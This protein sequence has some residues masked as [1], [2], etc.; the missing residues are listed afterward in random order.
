MKEYYLRSKFKPNE[1]W[2]LYTGDLKL[3][4]D[5][6]KNKSRVTQWYSLVFE[7]GFRDSITPI[8]SDVVRRL[9]NSIND[10]AYSKVEFKVNESVD[11]DIMDFVKT[12]EKSLQLFSEVGV[13]WSLV[14]GKYI[15][16]IYVND[17][18]D[19]KQTEF[20]IESHYYY[21]YYTEKINNQTEQY[22]LTTTIDGYFESNELFHLRNQKWIPVPIDTLD[23]LAEIPEEFNHGK[24]T[25]FIISYDSGFNN[26]ISLVELMD[27]ALSYM[28]HGTLLSMPRT[29]MPEDVAMKS[30][31]DKSVDKQSGLVSTLKTLV[32]NVIKV[33]YLD[34]NYQKIDTEQPV[35]QVDNY[36]KVKDTAL[37]EILN[38][39]G[40][41]PVSLGVESLSANTSGES[42]NAREKQTERFRD[43]LLSLRIPQL[44][45]MFEAVGLVVDITIKPFN[46]SVDVIAMEKLGKLVDNG[47][48]SKYTYLKLSFPHW[49]EKQIQDE[50]TKQNLQVGGLDLVDVAS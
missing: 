31:T 22:M 28:G 27:E 48:L 8:Q 9:I 44:K 33:P 24:E 21:H 10:I 32:C 12:L 16:K 40:I 34:N 4:E 47:D 43:N 45:K 49:D 17:L 2:S 19:Y 18:F 20:S 11:L 3:I 41:S 7:N 1:L 50:L 26:I 38:I 25:S 5:A 39:I 23:Y 29:Y 36:E 13:R 6:F 30:G 42:I 14:D 35:I 46:E 15:P 37:R